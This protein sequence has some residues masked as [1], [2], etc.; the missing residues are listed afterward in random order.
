MSLKERLVEDMKVA[1]KAK[2]EGK[3]R[4]SVIRMARAAIKNAEIDKQVEFNDEQV[5][6]VLAKE[7]KMRRD[8]IEEF[9]KA[10]RPDTVKALEKEISVL[11]EYLPQQLSEGEI[12]QLA[13]ETITEV[14]AQGPKDLG[15]VMG[16]ITPKTKGRA[17]GKLVNQIVRELLGS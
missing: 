6:E 9:S 2:E 14:G 17:D 15:K 12:R 1:M 4:L 10:N 3:V 7:V 11:M 16:K 13:Q 8:S 5:I